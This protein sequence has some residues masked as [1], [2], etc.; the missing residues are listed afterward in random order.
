MRFS[1]A[2]AACVAFVA[3]TASGSVGAGS[4]NPL[5]WAP[6][7]L[8][9]PVTITVTNANRRLFLDNARDYRLNIVE[10]LKRELW[11]EGGR[12]V[13]VI[14]GHITIDQLGGDSSYQDNTAVKVR[15][16]DPSG[17]VHLE[18]LLIDGPYVNDGIGI[19]TGRNVQIENVRVERAY[20]DDQG[21]PRRLRADPAGGGQPSH[22]SVHVQYA[23]PGHL[24]RRPRRPDPKC[25]PSPR[26]H[27]RG[28][29]EAS[30]LPDHA[31]PIPLL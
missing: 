20:D 18:G 6:P 13:V 31:A 8:S 3:S 23:A 12:N 5:T 15:F 2:I 28:G 19:A 21:R 11:I 14:G 26:E 16:G 30:A 25:R 29:W 17:T 7:A 1:T 4:Q 27:V 24:P 10:P 22:G 9:N